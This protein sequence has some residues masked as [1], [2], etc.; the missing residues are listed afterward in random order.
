MKNEKH[1]ELIKS[2]GSKVGGKENIAYFSH[3]MTRLRFNVKDQSKVVDL[4]EIQKIPG[5]L[6]AQWSSNQLQI[7]IGPTVSKVYAQICDELGLKKEEAIEDQINDKAKKKFGIGAILEDI[8]GSLS[9]LVPLLVGAGLVK[10]VVIVGELMGW[11]VPTMPTYQVLSFV[12]DSGFYFLPVFIGATAAKKFGANQGLGMLLGAIL[13][14]PTF[15]SSVAAGTPLSVFGLP[16]YGASYASSI[17]P[18]IIAVYILSHV[19][20]FFSKYAPEFLRTILVPFLSI[21][22]MMPLTLCLIAPAGAF[23]GIYLAEGVMWIYNTTGFLGVGLLSAIYPLLVITGMHGAFVPYMFQSFATYGYE[24]IVTVAGVFSNINQGA[25]AAAVAVK[26]KDK[27]TRAAAS[28]SALTAIIGGVT[29][30]AMFGVNLRLKTPLYASLIGNF[31][32]A[33]FAGFM[34]V[35]S[36]AFAGSAGIF[37]LVTNEPIL[38]AIISLFIGLIVTF[39]LTY[40]MYDGQ[41]I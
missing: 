4:E 35:R 18:S 28:S 22:V 34:K 7:V 23:L 33:G 1:E 14:H 37:A 30:P 21:L 5:V 16:I 31:C 29:E 32:A 17:F 36:V 10:V 27:D 12:A 8:S 26:C 40:I 20:R 41:K 6:G 11:L 13:I 39:V 25:A 2:I 15:I 19:E 9:P 38:Y 3:C 24:P